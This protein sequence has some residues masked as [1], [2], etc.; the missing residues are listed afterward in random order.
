[1][2]MRLHSFV[3]IACIAFASAC[4]TGPED[5]Q[6]SS[7][8]RDPALEARIDATRRYA[9]E[10]E[11]GCIADAVEVE[12]P[13]A[14]RESCTFDSRGDL[15]ERKD[16]R[17]L[18]TLP[19]GRSEMVLETVLE[20]QTPN[21]VAARCLCGKIEITALRNLRV[22]YAESAGEIGIRAQGN[23]TWFVDSPAQRERGASLRLVLPPRGSP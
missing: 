17:R 11:A 19:D 2:L 18:R 13:A 3:A 7:P 22:I 16:L 23:V 1:M 8:P 6:A 15:F 10:H 4:S 5:A 12:M 14:L 9:A 20:A 21:V